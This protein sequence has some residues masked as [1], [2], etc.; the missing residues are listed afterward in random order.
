MSC[1]PQPPGNYLSVAAASGSDCE[2]DITQATSIA[3]SVVDDNGTVI[4]GTLQVY[5]HGVT[6]G[7]NVFNFVPTTDALTNAVNSTLPTGDP[8][9]WGSFGPVK[10]N[11]VN[12]TATVGTFETVRGVQVDLDNNTRGIFLN[13]DNFNTTTVFETSNLQVADMTGYVVGANFT[14]ADPAFTGNINLRGTIDTVPLTPGGPAGVI[15]YQAQITAGTTQKVKAPYDA[16]T[17]LEGDI[18]QAT[19]I[20]FSVVDDNGNVIPGTLQVYSHGVTAGLNVFNFV[21]TT[22]ALTN[23]VNSTLPTGDPLNWGSFGPVKA[24]VVNPTATDEKLRSSW[25]FRDRGAH[26][27]ARDTCHETRY[28]RENNPHP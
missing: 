22:D 18:T 13:P 17:A 5:S 25:I 21:P 7:L 24:N 4:P 28:D 19:S 16:A 2:G 27:S 6:A 3:F 10:A 23:A 20:A 14:P 11:V 9:N 15:V 1:A 26:K 8:L 12:P